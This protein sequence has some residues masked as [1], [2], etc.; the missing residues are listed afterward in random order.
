MKVPPPCFKYFRITYSNSISRKFQFL[1]LHGLL[2]ED[3]DFESPDLGKNKPADRW[4][5]EDEDN[6]D[7]KVC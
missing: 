3:E 2:V 6:D 5:G 7:V 4:E 1:V